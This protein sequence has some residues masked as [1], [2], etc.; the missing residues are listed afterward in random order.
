MARQRPKKRAIIVHVLL[1]VDDGDSAREP[2]S[3]DGVVAEGGG[4][5]GDGGRTSTTVLASPEV[6]LARV[7][8]S[9]L[10]GFRVA[11]FDDSLILMSN[12]GSSCATD[13]WCP[14]PAGGSLCGRPNTCLQH[15]TVAGG[16]RIVETLI[17]GAANCSRDSEASPPQAK[18]CASIMLLP[19][20]GTYIPTTYLSTYLSSPFTICRY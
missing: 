5:R 4:C 8:Y 16:C 7:G 1:E 9:R 20:L 2:G 11:L 18:P 3:I 19:Y 10:A 13:L 15:Y 14:G 12:R 17:E 6:R